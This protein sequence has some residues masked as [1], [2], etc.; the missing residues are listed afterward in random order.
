MLELGAHL[1]GALEARTELEHCDDNKGEC[2]K[3]YIYIYLYVCM[4]ICMYVCICSCYLSSA[5]KTKESV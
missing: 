3:V 5:M 4:D 1:Q 2:V